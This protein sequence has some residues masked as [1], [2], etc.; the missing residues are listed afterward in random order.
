M[1]MEFARKSVSEKELTTMKLWAQEM[2]SGSNQKGGKT[3]FQWPESKEEEKKEV[4]DDV[5]DSD[6][7]D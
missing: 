6:L 7:Y 1:A 4:V 5:L 2:K 3:G